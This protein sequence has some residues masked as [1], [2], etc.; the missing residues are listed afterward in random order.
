LL[1]WFIL[2]VCVL[3]ALLLGGRWFV[4]ADPKLLARIVKWLGIGLLAIVVVVLVLTRNIGL[5]M[6]AAFVALMLLRR[7]GLRFPMG[8]GR[9]SGGQRS[10]V[11]SAYVTMTLDHDTGVIEGRVLSGRFAGR[12]LAELSLDELREKM[13]EKGFMDADEEEEADAEEGEPTP[14][15]E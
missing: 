15:V 10:E 1:G 7:R 12:D 3:A 4:N 8:G 5:L 11:E 14:E 9:P 6:T 13:Q 2:G